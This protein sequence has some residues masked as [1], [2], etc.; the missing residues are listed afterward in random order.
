MGDS[1]E[2]QEAYDD[3]FRLCAGKKREGGQN[4]NAFWDT[5]LLSR[6]NGGIMPTE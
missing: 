1:G 2:C 5:P 3:R 4:R 6:E